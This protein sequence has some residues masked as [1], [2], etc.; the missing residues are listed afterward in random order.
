MPSTRNVTNWQHWQF[1][2]SFIWQL[3]FCLCSQK[4]CE[5]CNRK[6]F[7]SLWKL[8]LVK[9]LELVTPM[10]GEQEQGL[11]DLLEPSKCSFNSNLELTCVDWWRGIFEPVID[12]FCRQQTS[13]IKLQVKTLLT[14]RGLVDCYICWLVTWN[15][16]FDFRTSS[17]R[18]LQRDQLCKKMQALTVW[19]SVLFLKMLCSAGSQKCH[20]NIHVKMCQCKVTQNCCRKDVWPSKTAF[21]KTWVEV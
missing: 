11:S 17:R 19:K 18:D 10:S 3:N 2:I 13:E 15:K 6:C 12:E 21:R 5:N 16:L 8:V 20:I 4:E 14:W 7:K 9:S 1:N